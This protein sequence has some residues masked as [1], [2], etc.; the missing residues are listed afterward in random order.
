[1]FVSVFSSKGAKL[2]QKKSLVDYKEKRDE[3]WDNK[4]EEHFPPK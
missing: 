1:M 2:T 4:D 3:G